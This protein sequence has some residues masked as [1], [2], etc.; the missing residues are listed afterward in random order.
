VLG[1]QAR[2]RCIFMSCRARQGA[3]VRSGHRRTSPRGS[4]SGS[5]TRFAATCWGSCRQ[6]SVMAGDYAPLRGQAGWDNEPARYEASHDREGVVRCGV[7]RGDVFHTRVTQHI[8]S[9][10]GSPRAVTIAAVHGP[11]ASSHGKPEA[12]LRRVASAAHPSS[13]GTNRVCRRASALTMSSECRS[14]SSDDVADTKSTRR[15]P[16]GNASPA[17]PSV[18]GGASSTRHHYLPAVPRRPHFLVRLG[19]TFREPHVLDTWTA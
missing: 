17:G 11:T 12:I 15:K 1:I 2:A 19:R 7:E 8:A 16:R 6:G 10:R 13:S 5:N 9:R 3:W 18:E 4:R 14:R